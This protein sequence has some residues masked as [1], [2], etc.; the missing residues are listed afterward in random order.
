M[1]NSRAVLVVCYIYSGL[2]MLLPSLLSNRADWKE[3]STETGSL[4]DPTSSTQTGEDGLCP[5]M[6]VGEVVRFQ[7]H[8]KVEVIRCGCEVD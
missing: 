3:S 6:V 8:F 5:K 2:F 4:Q 7:L 1:L